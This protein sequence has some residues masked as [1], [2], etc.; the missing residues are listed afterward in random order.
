MKILVIGTGLVGGAAVSALSERGHDVV[1]ASRSSSPAVD[2]TDPESI[3]AL[4]SAVGTVDAVVAAVGSAPYEPL[5][6]L[7]H[8]DFLKGLQAKAL[9]QIDIV[10]LGTPYVSDGGSFTLT[11]GV[12][13][14]EPTV[15]GAASSVANG[16]LQAFTMAAAIELP[17]HPDQHRQPDRSGGG[18]EP[19][20][21]LPRVHP[22]LRGGGRPGVRQGG[23][24]RADRPGY[25]LDGSRSA[26]DTKRH[27]HRRRSR[28][29]ISAYHLRRDGADVTIID[30][31]QT[32]RGAA[33]VN[34]GWIVP[35]ES[36]PVPGPGMISKSLKWM[37][38]RD[39]P[40]Y[41]RPSS[42]R[43]S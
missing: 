1:E 41:I 20:R 32:G 2:A 12:L 4:F 26:H 18:D 33:E 17:R 37:L 25:A 29:L 10:Q 11:T 43:S 8:D 27:R 35:A 24:R 15:T 36:A 19:P 22:G 3:A 13:G 5:A 14:R 7:D 42:T 23:G 30:A 39:S 9:A 38:R 21:R 6:E 28:G 34:A 31:R 40:L 16:A